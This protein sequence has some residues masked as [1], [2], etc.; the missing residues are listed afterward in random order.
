[1]KKTVIL[2]LVLAV[3]GCSDRRVPD[4]GS[5]DPYERALA[6][7]DFPLEEMTPEREAFLEKALA[8]EE[9]MFVRDAA[10]IVIGLIFVLHRQYTLGS[11]NLPAPQGEALASMIQ[12]IV[13]QDVP[14]YRYVAGAGLGVRFQVAAFR[15]KAV[16]GG[17]AEMPASLAA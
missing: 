3:G 7:L 1:M 13:S 2:L 9:A 17:L 14:T 10:L 15:S 16:A 11:E 12:G 5:D 4:L 6:I 8:P